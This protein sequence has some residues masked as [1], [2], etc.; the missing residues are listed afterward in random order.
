MTIADV[1]FGRLYRE[2]MQAAA[3][4][5][6]PPGAW[7]SRARDLQQKWRHSRYA[8]AFIARMDLSGARTLLDVGCGPGTIALPLASRL[9][10]VYGLDYSGAMLEALRANAAE[11]ELENVEAL[12]RAWEDDWSDVPACDIVVASRSM[13]VPDMAEALAKLNAAAR[14]RVYLTH[15]VER[16]QFDPGALEAM[17]RKLL[18][19]PDYIY[20]VNI[21]HAM[22]IHPRLDYIESEQRLAPAADFDEYARRI[23]WSLGEL[24]P[25]ELTRLRTWYERSHASSIQ[26][27]PGTMRWAFISWEKNHMP[28][29]RA[30]ESS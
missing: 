7:D 9:E 27:E 19:P 6:K 20:I 16:R 18:P 26:R 29:T 15:Q 5:P 14:R 22:G 11:M 28:R 8:E 17:G 30:P 2:H 13:N 1:D 24:A 25:G 12:H 10:R 3:R 21:L 23:A 4:I